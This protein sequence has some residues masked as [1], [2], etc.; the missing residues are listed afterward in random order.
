MFEKLNS[1]RTVFRK[2][3]WRRMKMEKV[4]L[5]RKNSP[6]MSNSLLEHCLVSQGHAHPLITLLTH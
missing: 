6:F 3:Q 5:K 2:T 1:V 4:M